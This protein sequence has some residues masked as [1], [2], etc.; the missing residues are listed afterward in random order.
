[1]KSSHEESYMVL[2]LSQ[3]AVGNNCQLLYW[4][5][6]YSNSNSNITSCRSPVNL[7]SVWYTTFVTLSEEKEA[8]V[9]T[10]LENQFKIVFL[11]SF[12]SHVLPSQKMENLHGER[13]FLRIVQSH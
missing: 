8:T 4:V 6:Y 12:V 3:I 2:H 11:S 7:N 5:K 9:Q 13:I 10:T 1:M